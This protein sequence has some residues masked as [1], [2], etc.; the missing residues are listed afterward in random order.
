VPLELTDQGLSIQSV[1][2][3]RT[4][5]G[6]SFR[7]AYGNSLRVDEKSRAGK[8]IGIF[9]EREA[10]VQEALEAVYHA[11]DPDAATGQAL[12]A[13]CAL[14]GTNQEPAS[15]SASPVI[16]CGD[17]GTVVGAASEISV[18]GTSERF[19]L[20]AGVTFVLAD[21]HA[22]DTVYA[23]GDTVRDGNG[24]VNFPTRIY[25]ATVGG[26]SGGGDG[27]GDLAETG[28]DIIDGTVHW[29][30]CGDGEA[31][32]DGD[33][34]ALT[35]GPVVASAGDL[36]VIEDS[37]PGWLTVRNLTAA[38]LGRDVETNED[39]RRRREE[40]LAREGTSVPDAIR[41]DVLNVDDVSSCTVFYNPTDFTDADGV[42]PHA[43]EVMVEGGEDQDI[44]DAMLAYVAAGIQT[45]GTETGAAVDSKGTSHVVKFS[46]PEEI[47]IYID[48][49]LIVDPDEYPDDGDDQ[50]EDAIVDYGNSQPAGKNAVALVI[51]AQAVK[52]DGVNDAPTIF[53]G[54]A[55]SPATSATVVITSR[56]KATYSAARITVATSEEEP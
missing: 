56:Q 23:V 13:I 54:T 53:I 42:P 49:T 32:A 52:V 4:E 31:F 33:A 55:P 18:V 47:A 26:M 11:T 36:S 50:V 9:S 14:T 12:V 41:G 8:L 46:R 16:L 6:T 29:A 38:S 27:P 24:T 3:I 35:T 45:H 10:L 34:T 44:Y 37:V 39:L 48:I 2:E 7:T 43:V 22:T 21:E 15:A 25:R 1:D 19:A 51:G 28:S 30:Y 5:L 17:D 40:E 20:D